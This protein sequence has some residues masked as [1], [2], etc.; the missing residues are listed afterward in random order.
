MECNLL[1]V[2]VLHKSALALA[3]CS[4]SEQ[5]YINCG[6]KF[7]GYLQIRGVLLPILLHG[8]CKLGTAPYLEPRLRCMLCRTNICSARQITTQ[9]G[10][11]KGGKGLLQKNYYAARV[12]FLLLV[13]SLLLDPCLREG[14]IRPKER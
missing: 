13:I 4:R 14:G 11:K 12:A 5:K 6:V 8:C 9:L 1:D 3:L 7:P 2:D 10:E